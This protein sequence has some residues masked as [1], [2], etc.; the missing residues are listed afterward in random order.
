V[1]LWLVIVLLVDLKNESAEE[2]PAA[3]ALETQNIRERVIIVREGW[4]RLR[5]A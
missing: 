5:G 4:K 3:D 1:G 2:I